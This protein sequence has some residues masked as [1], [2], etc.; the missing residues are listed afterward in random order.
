MKKTF[1]SIIAACFTC[2]SILASVPYPVLSKSFSTISFVGE[3]EKG[4]VFDIFWDVDN[5]RGVTV[6][7]VDGTGET[8]HMQQYKEKKSLKRFVISSDS[9]GTYTFIIRSGNL[10]YEKRFNVAVRYTETVE[11]TEKH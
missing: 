11:V 9:Q 3:K 5:D 8:I 2:F 4:L 6:Y 7:I 10:R 1:L